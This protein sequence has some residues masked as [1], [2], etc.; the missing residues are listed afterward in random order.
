MSTNAV[1]ERAEAALTDVGEVDV[2]LSAEA[3]HEPEADVF[4]LEEPEG[5]EEPAEEEE[6]EDDAPGSKAKPYT[7]KTLPEAYVTLK[8]DGEEQVVPLREMTDGYMRESAFRKRVS[9]AAE[10]TAKAKEAGER[11]KEESARFRT[12]FTELIKNPDELFSFLDDHSPEVLDA[13]S[14]KQLQ[15]MMAW[16]KDPQARMAHEYEKRQAALEKQRRRLEEERGEYQRTRQEQ[17]AHAQ[18]ISEFKPGYEAG[19]KRAGYPK[20]TDELR[21]TV[22]GLIAAR[23]A[24]A[25]KVTAKDVEEAVV[26]A[27]RAV[28]AETVASRKPAPPPAQVPGRRPEPAKRKPPPATGKSFSQ[29]FKDLGK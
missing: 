26:R 5:D 4:G 24:S 15:R 29:L 9:Q 12:S 10:L 17:E 25:G 7:V 19:M 23:R 20:V 22:K 28:G 27:A 18:Y 16:Q 14:R 3:A 11:F 8:I 13:V 6:P 1:M 21:E 2:D